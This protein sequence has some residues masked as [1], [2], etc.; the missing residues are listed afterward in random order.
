MTVAQLLEIL[1]S[2]PQDYEVEILNHHD[3]NISFVDE[4]TVFG[5]ECCT[6]PDDHP[7]VVLH[8][9]TWASK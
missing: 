9:E 3:R 7:V 6:E 2:V 8:T 4:V 1:K 5:P